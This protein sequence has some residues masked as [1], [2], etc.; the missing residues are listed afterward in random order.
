MFRYELEDLDKRLG[1][2]IDSWQYAW[3]RVPERYCAIALD[4]ANHPGRGATHCVWMEFNFTGASSHARRFELAVCKVDSIA[5]IL[6]RH[7]GAGLTTLCDPPH[8]V[9]K[10]LHSAMAFH[11]NRDGIPKRTLMGSQAWSDVSLGTNQTRSAEAKRRSKEKA[12]E[13]FDVAKKAFET[14][15]PDEIRDEVIAEALMELM[16]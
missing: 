4:L 11:F 2:I 1:K 10:R 12:A 9:G 14:G 7:A 5:N 3:R 8:L 6:R 15:D 13:I 16:I